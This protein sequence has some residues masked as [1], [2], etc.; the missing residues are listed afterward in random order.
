MKYSK[1]GG[2]VTWSGGTV[3]LS[4]GQSA[5][6]DHSLVI[7][8]PDIWTDVAPGASLK[9]QRPIEKGTRAPGE[10]RPGHLRD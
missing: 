7:E 2:V 5:E 3:L 6:D 10:K 9:T 8:R 1:I 4:E